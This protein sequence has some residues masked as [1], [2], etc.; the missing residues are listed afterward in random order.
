MKA[1]YVY[2]NEQQVGPLSKE[3][4]MA[5][6]SSGE[7]QPSDFIY[8]ESK[9]EWV[10]FLNHQAFAQAQ[11]KVQQKNKKSADLHPTPDQQ[12]W[13]VLQGDNRHGPF[14]FLE[15]VKMCQNGKV[16][17][18]DFL[19]RESFSG[20][21]KL[22]DITEF[23]ADSI[24]KV[25]D[26]KDSEASEAFFRRRHARVKYGASI[27]VHN[28][29]RVFKGNSIEISEGG[30]ALVLNTDEF[31]VNS[32]LFLHFKPGDGVPPFNAICSVV[33]VQPAQPGH[34]KY[35]VKFVSISQTVQMAIRGFA[36]LN[37]NKNSAA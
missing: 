34:F 22:A 13:F 28:Q 25:K 14:S 20:W 12:E 26:Q 30:A 36:E 9:K 31:S 32:N 3:E 5:K 8:D 19:W 17:P 4:I 6:L 16:Q 1:F 15:I 21:K 27:L 37:K 35:G 18:H 10:A 29:K 11:E 33:N 2:I 7:F 24:R 23:S